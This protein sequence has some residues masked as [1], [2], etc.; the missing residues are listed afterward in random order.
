MNSYPILIIAQKE[1]LTHLKNYWVVLVACLILIMNIAITGILGT[2][3]STE[4]DPR[5]ILLSLIH[6]H[7]YIIPLV[8]LILS[9]DS[10]LKERELGTLELFYAYPLQSYAL[11]MGKWLGHNIIL[12]MVI[13]IGLLPISYHLYQLEVLLTH[14]IGFILLI[15]ALGAVFNS[16]GLLLSMLVKERALAM[17][18]SIIVWLF[19]VFLFDLGFVTITIMTDGKISPQLLGGLLLLDP[20]EAFRIS[21]IMYLLPVDAVEIFSLNNGMLQLSTSIVA[22]LL[23]IFAPLAYLCY[24]SNNHG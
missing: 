8:A 7:M 2:F 11:V 17:L 3:F 15:F 20:V 14:I 1:V 9:C 12:F 10:I 6:L 18:V 23:W 5:A 24:K 19:F 13:V 22:T 4:L 21:A 16:L